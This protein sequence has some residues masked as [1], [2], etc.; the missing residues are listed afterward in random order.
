M[1]TINFLTFLCRI[2]FLNL[3]DLAMKVIAGEQPA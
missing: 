2:F 3:N 1:A